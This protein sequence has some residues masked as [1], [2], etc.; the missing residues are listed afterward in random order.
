MTPN[1][2]VD[3]KSEFS[4]QPENDLFLA[5][6]HERDIIFNFFTLFFF[7]RARE[8]SDPEAGVEF[9]LVCF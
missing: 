6:A 4:L 1:E 2:H 7:K 8:A 3:E 5:C 9:L